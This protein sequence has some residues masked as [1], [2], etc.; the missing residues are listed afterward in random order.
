MSR[1]LLASTVAAVALCLSLPALAQSDAATIIQSN[2]SG[3]AAYQDQPGGAS[4]SAYIY[5]QNGSGDFASQETNDP[6]NGPANNSVQQIN[7]GF[8]WFSPNTNASAQ[9]ADSSNHSF[10][11]IDQEANTNVSASQTIN[12]ANA[13]PGSGYYNNSQTATQDYNSNNASIQQWIGP[14][15]NTSGLNSSGNT[16]TASQ[17]GQTSNTS[18]IQQ[19][20]D[21]SSSGNTQQASE[22]DTFQNTLGGNSISQ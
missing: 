15:N 16:Q 12:A 20:I 10:Q 21:N 1:S 8:F 11:S 6:T 17:Y 4:N 2:E 5:Q 7:Q 9:Q 13:A 18:T 3:S 14:W 22:G 19:V